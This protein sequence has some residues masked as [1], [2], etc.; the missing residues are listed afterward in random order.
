MIQLFANLVSNAMNY[1]PHG[2]EVR[3][4]VDQ[5]GDNIIARVSDDGAG[6]IPDDQATLFQPF[7]RLDENT[8]GTGLGLYICRGI[9]EAHG[10]RI[11]VESEQGKGSDFVVELPLSAPSGSSSV[12][13]S[14]AAQ[15]IG[16]DSG[17]D[18]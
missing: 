15:P 12:D 9:V 18:E 2:S 3:I 17:T 4:H 14:A 11:W 6:I 7:T 1:S 16:I 5:H 13:K 8:L 10:G